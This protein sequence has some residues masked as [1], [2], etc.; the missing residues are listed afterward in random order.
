MLYKF[1]NILF[2]ISQFV[3]FRKS[4][5]EGAEKISFNEANLLIANHPSAF[6]DPIL[7]G[8][9]LNKPIYFLAAEEFMGGKRTSSFLE[10]QFNMIPIYR[11]TT[12]P[13]E[14][15]KNTNSFDKCYQA[16]KDKKSI[17]IFAE[18]HSE[19]QSWLDPLKTGT[20]RIAIEALVKFPELKKVNIVPIGLN[21]SN[22][23]QFRS[24][25]FLKIGNIIEVK[26]NHKFDKNELTSLAYENLRQSVN[27]LEKEESGWQEILVRIVKSK[28]GVKLGA[29]HRLID[30]FIF[31]L[32]KN[33]KE[34]ANIEL[35]GE[36]ESFDVELN[37]VNKNIEDF[38]F[39]K[40]ESPFNVLS[41]GILTFLFIPGFILNFIPL[42][43]IKIFV[44][45]KKFK[46]SFEGSMYF[47]FGT[48]FVVLWHLLVVISSSY[49][50]GWYSLLLPIVILILGW[51]SL[52]CRDY[53]FPVYKY[54]LTKRLFDQNSKLNQIYLRIETLLNPI[55][56]KIK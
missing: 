56:E 8:A 38:I 4:E 30:R 7:I 5:I 16:L 26:Q 40:N 44:K 49:F 51:L 20:A 55:L 37:K 6:K 10:S 25:F 31:E 33:N 13:D 28:F 48:L 2:R 12:R 43:L 22:P 11:P 19:T 45:N 27:G 9:N 50:F 35:K 34:T 14:I 46:Y 39:F 54:Y 1:L 47:G 53:L 17:L 32:R 42:Y 41:K 23:H 21:Y 52:K 36:V 3:Y 15:H 24:I 18:G 29:E